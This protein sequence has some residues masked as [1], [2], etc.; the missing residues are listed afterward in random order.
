MPK[1]L[2][3]LV[4]IALAMPA[5][6]QSGDVTKVRDQLA[7][8]RLT[9]NLTPARIFIVGYSDR[10]QDYLSYLYR[11][12]QVINSRSTV[13][14]QMVISIPDNFGPESMFDTSKMRPSGEPLASF[15]S[16]LAQ[17]KKSLRVGDG[18]GL[19]NLLIVKDSS[20]QNPWLQDIGEFVLTK[21]MG[22]KEF[23]PVLLDT[24]YRG[25]KDGSSQG[26]AVTQALGFDVINMENYGE[27]DPPSDGD[28]GGNIE[29][30]HEGR[31]LLGTNA[32]T[33]LKENLKKLTK[34]EPIMIDTSFLMVGHVDEIMSV[35]PTKDGC[36][37]GLIYADPVLALAAAYR[38]PSRFESRPL[39]AELKSNIEHF[40][41]PEARGKQS[42]SA[43]DF[44]FNQVPRVE[45]GLNNEGDWHV[46][47][48]LKVHL[49][50]KKNVE[51]VQNASRCLKT[52][53]PVATFYYLS[54]EYSFEDLNEKKNVLVPYVS[55]LNHVILNRHMLM[56]DGLFAKSVSQTLA[57][58]FDLASVSVVPSSV[59]ASYENAYGSLHCS[60]NVIRW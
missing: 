6:A 5:L 46:W 23:K 26:L 47:R 57:M 43:S 2:M 14:V 33:R 8:V 37:G 22:A 50:M 7:E 40:L 60:S 35:L 15:N 53:V 28:R 1:F 36:G 27:N 31:L 18:A 16:W 25:G 20:H 34:Q 58:L 42:I 38:D 55:T 44:D 59:M 11:L 51:A 45:D 56:P 52:I 12:I 24:N 4:S 32:T 19:P 9:S 21:K 30:T 54:P 3:S 39:L 29:A 17:L 13:Q 48:N 49:A 10:N 41:K